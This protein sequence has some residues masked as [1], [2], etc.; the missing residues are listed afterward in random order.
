MI[1]I[2]TLFITLAKSHVGAFTDPRDSSAVVAAGFFVALQA[3]YFAQQ[4]K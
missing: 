1:R 3:S 4:G 2:L